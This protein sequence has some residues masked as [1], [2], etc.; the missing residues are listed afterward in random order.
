MDEDVFEEMAELQH[1]LD[2]ALNRIA[3]L[4]ATQ[5]KRDLEQQ[6]KGV[7]IAINEV[8]NI[9]NAKAMR[10]KLYY[11]QKELRKKAEDL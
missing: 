6:A 11:V 10:N 4:E 9:S 3:E 7:Y 5:A 2:E 8:D 1:D